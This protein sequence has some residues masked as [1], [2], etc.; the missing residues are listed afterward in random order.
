MNCI[1]E[2]VKAPPRIPVEIEMNRFVRKFGGKT[3]SDVIATN[4]PTFA[5]ADYIFEKEN[6]IAELKCLTEDKSNDSK[7]K[8]RISALFERYVRSGRMPYF[9]GLR[10]IQSKDCP[11][12]L[13]KELYRIFARP[14]RRQLDKANQQIRETRKFL[15][16]ENAH[17]LVLLANDGNYRLEPAQLVHC[18]ELALGNRFSAIDTVVVFTV[19]MLASVP[20]ERSDIASHVSVW[21]PAGRV[22]HSEIAVGFLD[23]L[24][25]GWAR[26][27]G[28]FIDEDVPIA[29]DLDH[30][31]IAELRCDQLL[32]KARRPKE[33]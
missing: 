14:I 3:V 4:N 22:G 19:N 10:V 9:A 27:V 31:F 32:A 30:S 29:F 8:A 12:D 21:I 28:E 26:H 7:Q 25:A 24:A 23:R 13:Q 33:S 18:V 17:G 2:S 11:T 16:M 6:I 20:P 5:N 1:V 15:K